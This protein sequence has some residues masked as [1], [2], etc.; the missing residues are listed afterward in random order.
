MSLNSYSKILLICEPLE[1]A[2]QGLI[3]QDRRRG[4]ARDAPFVE[5]ILRRKLDTLANGPRLFCIDE[6][7]NQYA[8]QACRVSQMQE[9]R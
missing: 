2:R 8:T 7:K 1:A 3:P 5:P 4:F 9:R 6:P